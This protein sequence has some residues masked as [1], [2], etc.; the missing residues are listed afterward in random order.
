[1]GGKKRNRKASGEMKIMSDR[2]VTIATF[3][4]SIEAGFFKSRLEAE[5]IPTFLADENIAAT[6]WHYSLATGGIKLQVMEDD[7]ETALSVLRDVSAQTVVSRDEKPLEDREETMEGEHDD[8]DE[9]M[10]PADKM[11]SRALRSALF[12]LLLPPFQLYSIYIIFLLLLKERPLSGVNKRKIFATLA[13]CSYLAVL[14]WIFLGSGL[15]FVYLENG[16]ITIFA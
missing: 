8:A 1:M 5:G 15:L 12:G 16:E 3:E 4:N 7:V 10:S 2:P 6:V 9:V 11:A 13:L 14:V